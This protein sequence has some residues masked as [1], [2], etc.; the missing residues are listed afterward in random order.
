MRPVRLLLLA[1]MLA[2]GVAAARAAPSVIGQFPATGATGICPDAPLR[3]D[4]DAPVMLGVGGKIVIRDAAGAVADTIDLA[5][6]AQSR[7]VGGFP[8]RYQ[9]VVADGTSVT[10]RPHRTLDYGRTYTVTIEPAVLAAPDGTPWAGLGAPWSFGTRAVPPAAGSSHLVVAAD[11][12]GDFATVQG[13]IDFIPAGHPGWVT[14]TV[15]RGL[16][17]ERVNLPKGKDRVILRGEDRHGTVI[18]CA[19]N[20]VFNPLHRE[21]MGVQADE[22]VIRNLTLHNLTPKGGKQAEALRVQSDRC[23]LLEDDFA[24]F[25][26]TLRLD[27]RVA[28]TR[29]AIAGDVDFIWG[30]GTVFFDHCTLTALNN[31]YLVQARNGPGRLGYVFADCT[32]ATAPGLTRFVLGRI[33]P[34]IYP[35]SNVVFLRCRLGP[36]VSAAG[37]ELDR[38]AGRAAP[39]AAGGLPPAPARS[40]PGSPTVDNA[41]PAPQVRFWE[42]GSMDLA[43]QPLPAA[44]RLPCSRQLTADEAAALS[45]PVAVLDG[46]RHNP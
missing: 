10:I 7:V 4:F 33:D 28:V 1:G 2:A 3:L 39:G 37:W 17:G 40:Q 19:N 27:G 14:V 26:D 9:P 35:A 34:A 41:Q 22:V 13:A 31:G 36:G 20:A 15:R 5:A 45:D 43:G 32:V 42:Y 25:Q 16:Y 18:A 8:L 12:T 29:C 44:G 6:A 11:G 23:L 30:A 38:G 24:S 46:W 21:M